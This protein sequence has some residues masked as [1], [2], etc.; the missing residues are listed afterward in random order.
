MWSPIP[1]RSSTASTTYYVD[2]LHA[3][4]ITTG[5]EKFGGPVVI[6]ASV[7]GTGAGLQGG[8]I[9]FNRSAQNQRTGL[10]LST[11]WF[12]SRSPATRDVSAIQRLGVGL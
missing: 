4:D 10:L 12:I 8:M 9:T 11:G 5:A 2:R 3:L 1:R 7:P 6:Q